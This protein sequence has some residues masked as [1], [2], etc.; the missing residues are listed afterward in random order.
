MVYRSAFDLDF[1][2]NREFEANFEVFFLMMI[3]RY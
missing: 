2:N 1:A 3:F